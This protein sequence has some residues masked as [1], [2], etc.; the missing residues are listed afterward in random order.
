MISVTSK[1]YIND[2]FE[3]I[4]EAIGEVYLHYTATTPPFCPP[5]LKRRILA[6]FLTGFGLFAPLCL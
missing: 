4:G 5:F 6:E 2:I 3:A 1:T